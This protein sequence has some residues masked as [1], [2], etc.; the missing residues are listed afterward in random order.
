MVIEIDG[1]FGEGGGQ[2]LRVSVAL[3]ALVGK[4]I[5]IRKI[6][7]E[8]SP[9]GIRPQHLTAIKAVAVLS[10]AKVKGLSIGSNELEF[11]P[12]SISGGK[13]FFDS[14]TAASTT[15]ILQS[16]MPVMAFSREKTVVE[17]RGGTNNRWAPPVEYTRGVLLPTIAKT[18]FNVSV[19]LLKRG[20]YPKGGGLILASAEPIMRLKPLVLTELGAIQT[21]F[22]LSYSS[23][24]PCHI[25]KRMAQSANTALSKERLKEA[26]IFLECFQKKD[27]STAASPGCGLILIVK[28]STGAIFGVDSLGEIGKPAESIG[29]DV[30]KRLCEQLHSGAPIDKYLGDQLIPYIA[31]ANGRSEIKVK[32]LTLHTISCIHVAKAILGVDFKIVGELGKLSSIICNGIGFGR[33]DF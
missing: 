20:F 22:G 23:N 17:I 16:L 9:S 32:E 26:N 12:N 24:L 13:F 10:R 30:A 29:Q 15:L 3:A 18:G 6:R 5:K 25:V 4:P 8:R 11:Y 33:G 28:L 1:S 2:I 31:L 14:G 27:P 21:I 7:A 19:D